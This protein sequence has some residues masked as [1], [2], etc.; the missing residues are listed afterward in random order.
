MK[1]YLLDEIIKIKTKKYE[2]YRE[3]LLN[4]VFKAIKQAG[5]IFNFKRA[6]IIGS[7]TRENMFN[8]NSDIDIVVEDID[9]EYFFKLKIFLED[10]LNR[11]IDLI[12]LKDVHF[13][14]KI[15]KEGI[16]WKKEN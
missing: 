8:E 14:H 16:L 12:D 11:E 10:K 5:E 4:N 7:I 13:K 1:T 6:Y 15:L 2:L 9:P 3:N